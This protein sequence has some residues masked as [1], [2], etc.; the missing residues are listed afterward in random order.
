MPV[1]NRLQERASDHGV[2]YAGK[3]VRQVLLRFSEAEKG[4]QSGCLK[5]VIEI[6][7]LACFFTE[8][9]DKHSFQ[10]KTTKK[11]RLL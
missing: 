5:I 2:A 3:S 8:K 1:D 7:D 4:N 11:Y 10:G 9:G 6:T